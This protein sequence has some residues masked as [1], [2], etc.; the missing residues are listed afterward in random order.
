MS[1]ENEIIRVLC[2]AGPCGLSVHKIAL[3]VH[4]ACSSLFSPLDIGNVQGE[5]AAWLARNSRGSNAMVCRT[6]RRGVY[7]LNY[8]SKAVRQ[9]E[10]DFTG[11]GGNTALQQPEAQDKNGDTGTQLLLF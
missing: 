6:G 5:V 11:G 4:G 3:H 9:L 10:L 2:M 8:Q 7:S 1:Y